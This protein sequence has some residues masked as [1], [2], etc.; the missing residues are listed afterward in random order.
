MI[1]DARKLRLAVFF[2]IKPV[3]DHGPAF[4][5]HEEALDGVHSF[6]ECLLRGRRKIGQR[7]A[8]TRCCERALLR[9]DLLK[10]RLRRQI[11]RVASGDGEG[12][13]P[14]ARRGDIAD[15]TLNRL[16]PIC[17]NFIIERPDHLLDAGVRN[18]GFALLAKRV[19][20]FDDEAEDE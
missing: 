3:I 4:E 7:P 20:T 19:K 14:F 16:R 1:V 15:E 8:D 2:A 11:E 13:P 6:G 18:R 9:P 17:T 12:L 10:E 5:W